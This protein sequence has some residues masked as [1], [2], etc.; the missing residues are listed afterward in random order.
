MTVASYTGRRE[1]QL[2]DEMNLGVFL[3][4]FHTKDYPPAVGSAKS[5]PPHGSVQHVLVGL[6][7]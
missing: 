4:C 6:E 2:I 5:S 7:T 3:M 1:E